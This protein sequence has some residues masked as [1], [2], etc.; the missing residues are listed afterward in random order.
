MKR[1][2][3]ILKTVS[4]TNQRNLL[5]VSICLF[6]AIHIP[7][8]STSAAA[9]N[10]DISSQNDLILTASPISDVSRQLWQSRIALSADEDENS[11]NELKELIAQIN[12]VEFEGF[13]FGKT[14]HT[15]AEVNTIT[16]EKAEQRKE[17]QKVE[18]IVPETVIEKTTIPASHRKI[19]DET[20]EIFKKLSEKPEQLQSPAELAEILFHS[21]CFAQAANCYQEFLRRLETKKTARPEDKAWA[22]FQT[23]NCLEKDNPEKAI[24]SYH[25]LIVGYPDSVLSEIAKAKSKLLDWQIKDKPS[26]LLEGVCQ[27]ER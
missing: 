21:K 25:N 12:S 16:V 4:V 22:M 7:N 2:D 1:I 6:L 9:K 3:K 15:P 11:R 5:L 24:E 14:L 27:S 13:E 26:E 18:P 19:S 20:L 17:P 8:I 10:T 23:G